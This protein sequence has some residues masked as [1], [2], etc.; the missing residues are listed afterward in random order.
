MFIVDKAKNLVKGDT[1]NSAF[2]LFNEGI[3][4][5]AKHYKDVWYPINGE[6][7]WWVLENEFPNVKGD[8]TINVK[9][10]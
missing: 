10:I 1:I 7:G 8:E 6:Y 9:Y 2:Q 3:I 5:D 4:K